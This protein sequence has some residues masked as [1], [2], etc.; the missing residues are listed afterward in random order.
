MISDDRVELSVGIGEDT[1]VKKGTDR[2]D[3]NF[4]FHKF[5]HASKGLR[6]S[7]ELVQ[8]SMHRESRK[9]ERAQQCVSLC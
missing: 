3:V 7:E 6:T 1:R 5:L 2:A 4:Q 8:L 9:K